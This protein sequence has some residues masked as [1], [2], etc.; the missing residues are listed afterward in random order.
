MNSRI[1]K[2]IEPF[3]Y[4]GPALITLFIILVYPLGYSFWLSFHNWTLITFKEG[5]DFVALKNYYDVI[6]NIDFIHSL[7]VTFLFMFFAIFFE[8]ILGMSIALLLNLGFKGRNFFRTIILL[9]MMVTNVVIGLTWRLLLNLEYGLINKVIRYLGFN[10]V[11]WLSKTVLAMT[12]VIIVDIWNTS[13]FVALLLLAGLQTL[14]KDLYEAAKIDGSSKLQSFMYITLPLLKSSILVAL[15]WRIIDTFRI[16]D[17]P[18]LL[19]AG[20]PSRAT[21]MISLYVYRYGFRNFN[22]SYA[23]ASSYLMVI[24]MLI[25]AAF[26]FRIFRKDY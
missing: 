20:G 23:S 17:V 16:F 21:E 14:S 24:I 2:K 18:Y 25:F 7:L 9:P 3:F 6:L 13:S 11:P 5:V 19:T 8:F 10:A 12:S 4:I 22:L 1:F 15:L 26:L